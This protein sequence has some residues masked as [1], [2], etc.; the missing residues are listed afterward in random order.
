MTY[1]F[2]NYSPIYLQLMDIFL[3]NIL[4]EK[5]KIG[6][7]IPSVRDIAIEFSVNPNTVQKALQELERRE[8]LHSERTSGRFV[9]DDKKLLEKIR[10]EYTSSKI[11]DFVSEM[12]NFSYKL[13]ELIVMIEKAWEG[14]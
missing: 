12:K 4:S 10:N 11:N 5:W 3:I 7:K 1:K 8:I 6:E 9:S 13:S 2:D 14:K